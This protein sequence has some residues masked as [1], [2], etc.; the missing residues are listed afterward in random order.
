L[1]LKILW[2]EILKRFERIEVV[3]PEERVFSSFVHGISALPV[4]IPG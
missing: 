1:Q 3:G 2:E 4:R